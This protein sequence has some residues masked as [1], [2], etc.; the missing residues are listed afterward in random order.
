MKFIWAHSRREQLIALALT[1]LSFPILYLSLEL[2]KRIVNDAI[3]DAQPRNVF[4]VEF[5]PVGYLLLLSVALLGLV[6]INGLFKMRINTY[7]GIIGE[8][9]VRRL[10]YLL[11]DRVLRF[12]L[13]RFQRVSQGEI[14][15]P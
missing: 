13:A 12:P 2:P 5:D 9:L 15:A 11:V 4:G 7:K 8:R 6:I 10:R 14:I 3:S 1:L